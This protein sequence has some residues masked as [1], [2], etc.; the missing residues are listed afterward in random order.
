MKKSVVIIA[1]AP[2]LVDRGADA[3]AAELFTLVMAMGRTWTSQ[4]WVLKDFHFYH[5]SVEK[6]FFYQSVAVLL[7]VV[8]SQSLLGE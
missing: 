2:L 3:V 6:S 4:K 8:L 7:R 5:E 1:K